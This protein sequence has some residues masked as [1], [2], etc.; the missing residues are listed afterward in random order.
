MDPFFSP[1]VAAVNKNLLKYSAG[2]AIFCPVRNAV[3]DAKRWVLLTRGQ[4]TQG[5]CAACFDSKTAG[6]PIPGSVEVIDGRVLFKRTKQPLKKAAETTPE[7]RTTK[8][9]PKPTPKLPGAY[10]NR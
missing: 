9:A 6:R 2:R 1:M 4:H 3:A 10:F 5:V 7:I 8:P